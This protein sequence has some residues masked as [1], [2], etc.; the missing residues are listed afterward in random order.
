MSNVNAVSSFDPSSDASLTGCSI[1]ALAVCGMALAAFTLGKERAKKE[2]SR[3]Q[4]AWW[5]M[6]SAICLLMIALFI[7]VTFD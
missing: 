6:P 5:S 3:Y 4:L 7:L 2:G 1:C